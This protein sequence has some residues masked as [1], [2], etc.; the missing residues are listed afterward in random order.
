[1]LASQPRPNGP[2]GPPWLGAL[3]AMIRDPLGFYTQVLRDYYPIAHTRFGPAS[4]Y[5]VSD[6][7]LIEQVLVSQH[8]AFLKDR[9]THELRP[10]VGEGLLTSEGEVWKRQRRLASPAFQPK[11]ISAYADTMSECAERAFASYQEGELRDFHAD[12]MAITLEI[13]GKTLLGFDPRVES[14][15]V[16]RA[17]DVAVPY[18]EQRLFSLRM[19]LPMWLPTPSTRRFRRAKAELDDV[20][21]R[22]VERSRKATDKDDYLLARLVRATDDGGGGM[23]DQRLHDEAITMLLAGHETTA[24]TVMFAVYLLSREPAAAA[25]LRHEID[26]QLRGRRATVED[27]TQLPY[28]EAFVKETLRLYP[29]APVLG[30]TVVAPLELGG[31][32]IAPTETVVVSPFAV[33]RDAR[34]YPDPDSFSPERWLDGSTQ[35]LP[36]FAYFPF[37]GG[38]RVCIGNHFALMEAKLILASLVQQLSLEVDSDFQLEL[39][40]VVTLRSRH[41]LPVR[42]HRRGGTRAEAGPAPAGPPGEAHP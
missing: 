12:V 6:P 19:F 40:P 30:R 5:I 8:Q 9:A 14:E 36:R 41:G 4:V 18:F 39:V 17:M 11:R 20:V 35:G 27:L 37:G 7:A 25:R 3:P 33:Q 42:V 16:A 10:L 26:G 1:M 21:R 29:A 15:R 32:A 28:L 13:V 34:W 24:L 38:P 23:S 2:K 22:I 31:Y